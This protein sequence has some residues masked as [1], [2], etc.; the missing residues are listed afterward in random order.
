M[1]ASYSIEKITIRNLTTGFAVNLEF[2]GHSERVAMAYSFGEAESSAE[3]AL[4]AFL[5]AAD[6]FQHENKNELEDVTA[7]HYQMLE[8]QN[9]KQFS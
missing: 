2:D 6:F 3:A 7:R 9:L 8:R 1:K 4:R 5:V